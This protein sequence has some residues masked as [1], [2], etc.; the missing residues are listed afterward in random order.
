MVK[1]F[2]CLNS[3]HYEPCYS[4]RCLIPGLGARPIGVEQLAERA[5]QRSVTT[6]AARRLN[7]L[8]LSE[9]K[10]ADH[11]QGFGR[12]AVLQVAG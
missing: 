11:L 6:K 12:R 2:S 10:V 8:E 9:I 4:A 1:Y 7:R 5:G 3:L